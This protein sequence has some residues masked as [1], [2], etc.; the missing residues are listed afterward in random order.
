M[1]KYQYNSDIRSELH[2]YEE[3]DVCMFN[4]C[5]H[6]QYAIIIEQEKLATT[7]LTSQFV[8]QCCGSTSGMT[9]SKY[10]TKPIHQEIA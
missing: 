5:I 7:K 9:F 8:H 2:E 6:N 1:C 10:C 4:K 3:L